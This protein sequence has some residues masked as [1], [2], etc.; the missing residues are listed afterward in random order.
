MARQAQLPPVRIA[1]IG[2]TG[3]GKTTFVSRVTG[4]TDLE[5]DD[6]VDSVTQD[7]VSV[8]CTIDGRQVTLID[9][10]GFDDPGKGR[11]DVDIL[12]LVSKHLMD[13]HGRDTKL[14]GVVLLQLV[15]NARVGASEAF[16]TRLFKM[17]IGEESYDRVVIGGTHAKDH[18][19]GQNRVDKR[20]AR[21]DI[22]G[23][24]VKRGARAL[25]YRD[26]QKEALR[27][28]RWLMECDAK[29]IKLQ[30]EL[31]SG[32]TLEETAAG[33]EINKQKSE[34]VIKLQDKL[35]DL[36][37]DRDATKAEIDDLRDKIYHREQEIMDLKRGC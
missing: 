11:S 20:T 16:R 24:M 23:G 22:W 19:E 28:V 6:G 9:T 15:S 27:I 34:E 13:R 10:P 14:N 7:A 4:N 18:K 37:S 35:R 29:H 31:A 33:K 32:K 3:A 1:V 5:I 30:E 26:N 8:S 17:M 2:P 25:P 21:P 36:Q 12:R